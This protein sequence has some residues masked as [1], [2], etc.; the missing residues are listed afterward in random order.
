MLCIY[1]ALSGMI[2]QKEM[3][4]KQTQASERA[5]EQKR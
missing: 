1:L 2:F 3:N 4:T 5:S